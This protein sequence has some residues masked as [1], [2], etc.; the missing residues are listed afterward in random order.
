MT[1]RA[2]LCPSLYDLQCFTTCT[3]ASGERTK[4]LKGHTRTSQTSIYGTKWRLRYA[5]V[6][7]N[8]SRASLQK[9]PSP[10]SRVIWWETPITQLCPWCAWISWVL[11][12]LLVRARRGRQFIF[13]VIVDPFSHRIWL[14]TIADKRAETIYE[15]FLRRIL[16]EWGPPRAVLTDNG[17]EFD[18]QLLKEL[19]RLWRIKLCYT[20]PLHPQSN[21][22][23]SG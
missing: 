5:A 22:K 19:C 2:R 3:A 9:G 7:R 13:F 21:Y 16:L 20:P 11:S 14:E 12:C 10:V 17:T 18:N 23:Q 15:V 6:W 1:R 4:G 8:V